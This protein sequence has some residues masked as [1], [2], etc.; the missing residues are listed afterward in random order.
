M[1]KIIITLGA[2]ILMSCETPTEDYKPKEEPRSRAVSNLR[3]FIQDI[4]GG[5]WVINIDS[6]EY[7]YH[8]GNGSETLVHKQNCKN[9]K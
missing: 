7:I 6:C 1:K 5:F 9:H 4:D 3:V 2:L 8:R